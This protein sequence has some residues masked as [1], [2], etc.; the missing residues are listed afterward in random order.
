M[1]LEKWRRAAHKFRDAT[2]A[3]S[4]VPVDAYKG[5][6]ELPREDQA[7]AVELIA[8]ESPISIVNAPSRE[9]RD[10]IFG[11]LAGG[12]STDYDQRQFSPNVPK[13][14]VNARYWTN[15]SPAYPGHSSLRR[16]FWHAYPYDE[17]VAL[18]RPDLDFLKFRPFDARTSSGGSFHA[19]WPKVNFGGFADY[20]GAH[21]IGNG[22]WV[23]QSR[24][25]ELSDT[26][27]RRHGWDIN[28]DGTKGDDLRDKGAYLDPY[29]QEESPGWFDTIRRGRVRVGTRRVQI[30]IRQWYSPRGRIPGYGWSE[31]R[32]CQ[33]VEEPVYEDAWFRASQGD[34]RLW[35][36][37]L[38]ASK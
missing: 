9:V 11:L 31:T 21:S 22:V 8:K 16:Y 7:K 24:F 12:I 23:A 15:N 28:L 13:E 10:R 18:F 38:D 19:V 14:I 26:L 4:K 25:K 29:N 20:V 17:Q 30:P 36:T 27:I 6:E 35:E 3:D 34:C 32:G 5:I 2:T 33:T 37:Y 1:S